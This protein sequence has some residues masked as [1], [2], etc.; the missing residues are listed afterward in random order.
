MERTY[1]KDLASK[2][3]EEVSISGWVDVRRDHGKLIFID[4]R[5][6]SGKV[7][8]V[9]L[10]N[11]AEAQKIASSLRSEWVIKLDG[12]VNKRPEKMIKAGDPNG[13]I[14]FEVKKIEVLSM[15][16]ELPF[17]LTADIN[18][19]T[20]LDNLPLTLRAEKHS[21]VFRIQAVIVGAFRE[22]FGSKNFIEFQAPKL[23]G[24]DAEGGAN[25]FNIEYFGHTAHLAQSPQLYKQIMVGV[26]ERVFAI[27]N[28]YRAE[29]HSTTRHLNEYTSMDIEMGFIKDHEDIMN[30]ENEFMVYLA[31]AL[32]EKCSREFD[33]LGGTIP[34]V[35]AKMP[36]M[37]L[38]QAQ[39]LITEKTGKDCT[40]EPDLEPEHERWLCDYT[41]NELG[42]EFIF[43]TNFPTAKR[44]FYTYRDEKDPTYTKGFDLLFRGVEITTGAQRI[45][46][47]DD[48]VASMVE[49]KLNPEKFSYY[50][51]AFKYGIPPHGGFGL[52]LERLT[53][54]FLGIENVKE[55]TLFPRD[56]NR[57]DNRLSK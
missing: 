51:Q 50:L 5:D 44:P 43:I 56:I 13:T 23:I 3:G 48:L 12:Q 6:V 17:E 8:A 32:K 15:A 27:G 26:F 57:I 25:S 18:I 14:E 21:A 22:F 9:I 2:I 55:A 45:H 29:K 46:N 40:S 30:I 7:Q 20:Y 4:L 38:R 34:E 54:K 19:D 41:K 42:S 28:V 35:P 24:D 37:S 1:V 31:K 16:K 10:P 49:K 39:K 53:A 52:G 47:Y 36:R 33:L 11:H